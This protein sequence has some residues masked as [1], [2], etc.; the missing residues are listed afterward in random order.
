MCFEK[1]SVTY[2]SQA[3]A[4]KT[5]EEYDAKA[6]AAKDAYAKRLEAA[7]SAA[8]RQGDNERVM[9]IRE[10][11][12]AVGVAQKDAA[13]TLAQQTAIARVP[14]KSPVVG[15]DDGKAF[16]D[17]VKGR[18]FLV[19]LKLS[20]HSPYNNLM[21][22]GIQP[23]YVTAA[24]EQFGATIG[25]LSKDAVLTKAKPG[26]AV[27]KIVV[28]KSWVSFKAARSPS[29]AS[30]ATHWIPPTH[31]NPIGLARSPASRWSPSTRRAILLL[32]SM[33]SKASRA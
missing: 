12:D 16:M 18:G 4:D 5:K 30:R 21:V 17:C 23:V 2:F 3:A 20:W 32:E 6:K 25:S 8:T 24:G 26:Y 19:G 7:M 33:E 15:N 9:K 29:P 27:G 14:T 11:L 10:M 1:K 28:V 22:N 13:N 31:T